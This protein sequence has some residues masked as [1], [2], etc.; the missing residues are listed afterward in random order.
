MKKYLLRSFTRMA[1]ISDET[2]IFEKRE[3]T[4]AFVLVLDSFVKVLASVWNWGFMN[5]RATVTVGT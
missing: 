5:I 4:R 3:L 2:T 1:A